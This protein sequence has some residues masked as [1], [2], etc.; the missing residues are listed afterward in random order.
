MEELAR[1]NHKNH[2]KTN[3]LFKHVDI[4]FWNTWLMEKKITIID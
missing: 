3:T 2:I 1:K 4:L